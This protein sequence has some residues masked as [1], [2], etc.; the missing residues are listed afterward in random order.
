MPGVP[1]LALTATATL[2]VQ[3][4]ILKLLKIKKAKQFQVRTSHSIT[5]ALLL[6]MLSTASIASC[7]ATA[8]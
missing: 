8:A 7:L 4:D 3:K 1:T 6:P 5:S 2:E